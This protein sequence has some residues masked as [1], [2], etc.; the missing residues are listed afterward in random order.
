M[1]FFNLGGKKS[2][3][4]IPHAE[5]LK[6]N[7][8]RNKKRFSNESKN[9][10]LVTLEEVTLTVTRSRRISRNPSNWWVVKSEQS[11]YF[12][13]NC[14]HWEIPKSCSVRGFL[15]DLYSYYLEKI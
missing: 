1:I 6:R 8:N 7:S 13:L 15:F 11:K 14:V 4:N 5:N 9:N 3:I 12:Y 10:K 2:S